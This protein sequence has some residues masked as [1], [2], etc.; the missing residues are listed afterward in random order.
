[1][2][3]SSEKQPVKRSAAESF[4]SRRPDRTA[5][6]PGVGVVCTVCGRVTSNEVGYV[7]EFAYGADGLERY[8]VHLDC[9]AAWD[10]E[11]TNIEGQCRGTLS[12]RRAATSTPPSRTTASG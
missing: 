6:G 8:D 3:S 5:T 10:L 1:M 12:L 9:F 2:N 4:P 7:M 11:R